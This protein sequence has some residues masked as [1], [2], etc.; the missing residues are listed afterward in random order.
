[1]RKSNEVVMRQAGIIPMFI[2]AVCM[3]VVLLSPLPV[4]AQA[5]LGEA[6][7]APACEW[8][9]YG[10]TS[11]QASWMVSNSQETHDGADAVAMVGSASCN[12]SFDPITG[13]PMPGFPGMANPVVESAVPVMV[14]LPSVCSFWY[15]VTSPQGTGFFNAGTS[16]MP[17]VYD[18]GGWKQGLVDIGSGSQSFRF[19]L[20][21]N[22][23]SPGWITAGLL[24]DQFAIEPMP[25]IAI[26]D[27]SVV[28]GN[29]GLASLVF[30]VSLSGAAPFDVTADVAVSGG[31]A[32]VLNPPN[33]V[34]IPKGAT[35]VQLI[36]SVV[37]DTIHEGNREV[38]VQISNPQHAFLT[39]ASAVGTIIDD[40]P[41]PPRMGIRLLSDAV[42]LSWNTNLGWAY[43]IQSTTN[44]LS[45]AEW[46]DVPPYVDM[47][48][49]G[50]T[51]SANLTIDSA[52]RF[53]RIK[54]VQAGP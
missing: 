29:G 40:D 16:G 24:V 4:T 20:Y 47:P 30:N 26:S 22:N 28:E 49:D 13:M 8:R 7:D 5:W 46:S 12:P 51:S 44:L 15:A 43:T 35:Q 17:L 50:G 42:Q 11:G 31:N 6:L 21:V 36:L 27:A 10:A 3:A 32:D 9:Y 39:T 48:G 2:P 25:G 18:G 38:R 37:G 52:A 1:M 23:Y 45:P 41:A 33:K 53:F 34:L 19:D 54:A 14:P